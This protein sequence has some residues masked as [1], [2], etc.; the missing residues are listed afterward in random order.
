MLIAI[1]ENPLATIEDLAE[2]TK[3][4]KPTLAKRLS[5]L[6]GTRPQNL[7]FED[8]E[9]GRFFTVI[10]NLSYHNLGFEYVGMIVETKQLKQTKQVEKIATKHPYTQYR[11]RCYGASN[12]VLLQFRTPVGTREQI[13]QLADKM[14]EKGIG[15]SYR[16]LPADGN[17]PVYTSLNAKG[18]IPKALSWDFNW[19]QWFELNGTGAIRK[20]PKG[21]QGK[22][23][24]W[25]T[26]KDMH[27]IQET[28]RNARRK[29]KEIMKAVQA[30]GI[31]FTPQ[32]FSRRYN[33]MR[34]E[35]FESYR[36]LFD[37]SIFDVYNN[38]VIIGEGSKRFLNR[39]QIRMDS[40]PIPFE[41]SLRIVGTE[42]FWYVRLQASH[43]SQLIS[44]LSSKLT[45]MDLY[46]LDYNHSLI[47][48]L[49]PDAYDE[50]NHAWKHD[51][52]FMIHDVLK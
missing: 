36:T 10:P 30:Q 5:V 18:W 17:P 24:A 31:A 9:Q 19:S 20:K 46:L 32:T 6:E 8:P 35:C 39:L 2:R 48:F 44:T 28:M 3:V 23:L 22:S 33:M 21:E 11:A 26:K 29:N 49:W 15:E 1:Q 37:P 38:I 14:V 7:A 51:D 50:D 16:E 34:E 27:V 40:N 25:L 4:S 41:S 45:G 12:G 43:L 47:Y 13:I 42:M 52:D